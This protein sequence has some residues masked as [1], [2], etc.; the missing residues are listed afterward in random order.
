M[1]VYEVRR[2]RL[3]ELIDTRY[4]KVSAAF[5]EKHEKQPSYI[6]RCLLPLGKPHR[7]RIGEDFAREIE[8]VERLPKG[9]MDEMVGSPVAIA[10]KSESELDGLEL[11]EKGLRA[12]VIVGR[13]KDEILRMVE[14]AR[15]EAEQY[16][17]AVLAD[18]ARK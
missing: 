4:N 17:A 12:L 14:E 18:L 2:K 7:K 10:I 9:W 1:D 11:I 15:E 5:A 6:S 8:K 13:R 16:K 3:R